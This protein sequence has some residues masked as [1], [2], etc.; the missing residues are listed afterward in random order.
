MGQQADAVFAGSV[1]ELY[2]RYLVP[3][4]FAPYA[5]DLAA[6]VATHRPERVLEIAAGTGVLTRELAA[7][8]PRSRIVATDLNRPMLDRASATG[9]PRPVEWRQADALQL[10]YED[11][12]FDAVVCQFGCMFFPDKPKAFS[13]ARR[14]LAPGGTLLFNVWDSIEDNEF[15]DVVTEA[16]AGLWPAD[17]PRFLART[18]HGYHDRQ[19]IEGDL[20]RG[21][22]TRP[23]RM[24]TLSARSRAAS[25]RIPAF[26]Y[27]QG[28]PM[29]GEIEARSSG[30]LADATVA[31]T[32]AIADR[33]GGGPIEGLIQAHVV[34]AQS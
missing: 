10:P 28:T 14:V 15:A 33:F 25:P 22:L 29:R 23:P 13:E 7:A 1:P 8:L 6:R 2:E 4:I 9:T 16:L 27:C 19:A 31:C 18:P 34:T 30:G 20:R 32:T 12:A 21:G 5:K 3:L 24:E 17:P 11:G 26:A